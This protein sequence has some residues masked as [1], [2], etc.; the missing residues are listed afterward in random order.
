MDNTLHKTSTSRE[1][2]RLL[3]HFSP[4]SARGAIWASRDIYGICEVVAIHHRL[5][6]RLYR[7]PRPI[8]LEGVNAPLLPPRGIV[9]RSDRQ[10]P[11]RRSQCPMTHSAS[12]RVT[13]CR[14]WTSLRGIAVGQTAIPCAIGG[15]VGRGFAGIGSMV[16]RRV[17]LPAGLPRE[18]AS[19]RLVRASRRWIERVERYA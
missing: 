7:S 5:D 6:H 12:M 16:G 11:R 3:P 9:R 4:W 14:M 2:C 1:L 8:Q 10:R 17:T 13:N 15:I 18:S 19:R